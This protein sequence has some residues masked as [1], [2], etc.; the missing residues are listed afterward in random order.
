M[1]L[2][3]WR[4][5]NFYQSIHELYIKKYNSYY[6]FSSNFWVIGKFKDRFDYYEVSEKWLEEYKDKLKDDD[7]AD[8]YVATRYDKHDDCKYFICALKKF[9]DEE[10]LV[11]DILK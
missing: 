6:S 5:D 2:I 9:T 7:K 1:N 3:D 8:V 11:R 10:L 4:S